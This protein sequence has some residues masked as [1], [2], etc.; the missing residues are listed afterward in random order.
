V[1]LPNG[2]SYEG[3]WLGEVI[4]GYGTMKYLNGEYS[5][6]FLNNQRHGTGIFKQNNG[7]EYTGAYRYDKKE[8]LGF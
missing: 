6:Q 8:G 7:D 1:E 2:N 5:G 3:E 4:D